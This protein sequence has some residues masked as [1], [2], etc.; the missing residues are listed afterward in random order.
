MYEVSSYYSQLQ[1]YN[2]NM[3]LNQYNLIGHQFNL[4]T[5]VNPVNV[6]N[7]MIIPPTLLRPTGSEG[8]QRNSL[9]FQMNP[10]S[11]NKKK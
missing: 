10:I 6:M 2:S 1:G 5:N 7:P 3:D 11:K 4:M 8:Q 9:G